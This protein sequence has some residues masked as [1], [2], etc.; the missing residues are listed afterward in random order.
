MIRLDERTNNISELLNARLE[1]L[2]EVV[3]KGITKTELKVT[4]LKVW[5][6]TTAFGVFVT[7]L[8]L[9]LRAILPELIESINSPA[10]IESINSPEVMESNNHSEE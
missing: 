9:L 4:E 1:S 8:F 2:K 6:L 10:V 5:I 3:D 7:L